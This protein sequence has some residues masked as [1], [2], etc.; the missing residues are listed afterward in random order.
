MREF[1]D[2]S[3]FPYVIK[4]ARYCG[5]EPGQITK[6]HVGRVTCL[7]TVTNR[8]DRGANSPLT[9]SH[10]HYLNSY[11]SIACERV[12]AP[13]RDAEAILRSKQIPLF[14]IESTRPAKDF[15]C[16]ALLCLE[17]LEFPLIPVL[18]ELDGLDGIIVPGGFGNRG[19]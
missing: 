18:L 17:Q 9:Q 11:D 10:Y 12:F 16:I 4:P 1:L 7:L 19:V 15:D 3:F 2:K 8:Y 14:S 6:D 13:D 5:G